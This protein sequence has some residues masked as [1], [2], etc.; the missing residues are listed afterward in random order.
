[1]HFVV[2]NSVYRWCYAKTVV[3]AAVMLA[4]VDYGKWPRLVSMVVGL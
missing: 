4:V 3:A 1:M 2:D